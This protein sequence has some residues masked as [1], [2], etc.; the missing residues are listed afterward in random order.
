MKNLEY[1]LNKSISHPKNIKVWL[2]KNKGKYFSSKEIADGLVKDLRGKCEEK[3]E[4]T[5]VETEEE[6]RKQVQAEISARKL[7]LK[8]LGIKIKEEKGNLYFCC[9]DEKMSNFSNKETSSAKFK[10][11]PLNQILYGPPGTGKTY[12]TINRALAIIESKSL[13][14]LENEDREELKKRFEEY[15]KAGQIEFITFHQS[16]SYE[17][18]V[19]GIK[20][21]SDENGNI[22]Y[23]I[24]DGIFKKLCRKANNSVFYIGQQIGKYKIISLSDE[25]MKLKRESGSIIPIPL[26]LLD[27][28]IELI[29]KAKIS[30][31]NIKNKTAIEKMGVKAEKYIVNGYPNVFAQLVEYY[32]NNKFENFKNKNYILI[33]DEINRGNISKIFG[34]LITLIEESK[35]IGADEEIK[36]RLPY[37]NEEFGVPKN[38]YILGTMNTADRSI[39]LL[40]TALR[41]RFEFIEMMPKSEL[42]EGIEVDGIDIKNMLEII[43][44]RIE[45]LYDRDHMIG[46][47]YFMSLKNN[48]TIEELTNIFRNKIIPLLQEYFYDDFEKIM[49]VLGEGFIDRKEI[50]SDI[51]DYQIDDYLD[52][53]KFI[54]EIKENFDFSKFKK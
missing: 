51:F 28:L 12:N 36:V 1:D 10:Y 24:R 26:Y 45:Y 16:Y 34:E 8:E 23:E 42:L 53:E 22:I 29:E 21:E 50:K 5:S 41:R 11:I 13:D 18:F 49:M 46:H 7:L 20:A 47:S 48:Q 38:L 30:I 2:C 3:I 54:Y 4:K 25:L 33:I 14:E 32:I 6:C 52:E 15:K 27:E 37:S 17:E 40:D 43:N 35:R 44:K 39:A 19:E 9:C 31:N